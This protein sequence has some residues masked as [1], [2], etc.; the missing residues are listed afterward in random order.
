MFSHKSKTAGLP[1]PSSDRN[2]WRQLPQ[3]PWALRMVI[4]LGCSK[5][6]M[7]LLSLMTK[8][9][10]DTLNASL[11]AG[12]GREGEGST[13]GVRTFFNAG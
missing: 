11:Y 6:K 12:T 13:R 1:L 4:L 5:D 10:N 3:L 8:L 7:S 9:V 2:A